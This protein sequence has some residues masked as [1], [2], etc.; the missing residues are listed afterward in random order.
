MRIAWQGNC[1]TRKKLAK[2]IDVSRSHGENSISFSAEVRQAC[3]RCAHDRTPKTQCLE[4]DLPESTLS[5]ELAD[6]IREP[7]L[8]AGENLPVREQAALRP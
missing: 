8:R 6:P 1:Q 5:Q 2:F 4:I 3:M 7:R